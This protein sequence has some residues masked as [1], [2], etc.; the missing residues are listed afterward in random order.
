MDGEIGTFEFGLGQTWEDFLG[1]DGI[2]VFGKNGLR[3]IRSRGG[4]FWL[5]TI[6]DGDFEGIFEDIIIDG[7]TYYITYK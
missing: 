2:F 1:E 5:L 4:E 3:R 7:K 6:G